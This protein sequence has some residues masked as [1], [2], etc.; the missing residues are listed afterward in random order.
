MYDLDELYIDIFE[1]N[2][3]FSWKSNVWN[4][5]FIQKNHNDLLWEIII[6]KQ[7]YLI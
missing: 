1:N 5:F 2:I 3:Y 7:I 4:T 6:N